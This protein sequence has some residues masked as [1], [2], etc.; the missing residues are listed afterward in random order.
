MV[1]AMTSQSGRDSSMKQPLGYPWSSTSH[2]TW[3][4]G[5]RFWWWVEGHSWASC[6]VSWAG[7]FQVPWARCKWELLCSCLLWPQ[8][9]CN[10]R[11][12]HF[13]GTPEERMEQNEV[14]I[15]F[16]PSDD[17]RRSTV[18]SLTTWVLKYFKKGKFKIVLLVLIGSPELSFLALGTQEVVLSFDNTRETGWPKQSLWGCWT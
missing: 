8:G 12:Q 18:G 9:H 14:V 17:V 1:R 11:A 6:R 10:S 2:L 4:L 3:L 13:R 5:T 16:S 7:V 15:Q